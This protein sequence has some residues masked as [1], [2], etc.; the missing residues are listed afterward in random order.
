MIKSHLQLNSVILQRRHP[1]FWQ[2]VYP[3]HKKKKTCVSEAILCSTLISY[4]CF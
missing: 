2:L 4:P 1:P 3:E